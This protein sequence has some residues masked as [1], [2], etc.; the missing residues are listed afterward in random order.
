MITAIFNKA[1]MKFPFINIIRK[2]N[3][4]MKNFKYIMMLFI[5]S[6][7]L[8]SQA[9]SIEKSIEARQSYMNLFAFNL[10]I[11]G[12]MAKGKSEY[13]AELAKIAAKNLLSLAKMNNT[14]MW[15]EGSSNQDEDGK[16]ITRAKPAL[17]STY[18]EVINKHEKLV[19]ALERFSLLASDGIENLQKGM[20]SVGR[21][22][23]GCHKKFRAK[24]K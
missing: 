10:G 17:W 14:T 24:N 19:T 13:N 18:P 3:A 11:T 2:R 4:R 5:A 15:P 1:P 16:G 23:G 22:C 12:D 8:N 20:K 6:L 21:G 7:A 9:A